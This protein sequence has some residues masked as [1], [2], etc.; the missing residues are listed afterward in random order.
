MPADDGGSPITGYR[1]YL[2]S[3]LVYDGNGTSTQNNYTVTN[4]IVGH[5]FTISVSALNNKGEGLSQ[6]SIVLSSSSVP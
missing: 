1:L 6:A 3:V 5:D 4:L 2:N